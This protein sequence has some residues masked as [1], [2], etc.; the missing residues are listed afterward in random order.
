MGRNDVRVVRLLGS[1]DGVHELD[2]AGVVLRTPPVPRVLTHM[3]VGE[4][5]DLEGAVVAER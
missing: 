5:G 3:Q 2:R 1:E 4:H